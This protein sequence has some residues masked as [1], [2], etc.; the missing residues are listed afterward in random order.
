MLMLLL[1]DFEVFTPVLSKFSESHEEGII[2]KL[3]MGEKKMHRDNVM[4][5]K[6]HNGWG[7]ETSEGSGQAFTVLVQEPE[8]TRSPV[9]IQECNTCHLGSPSQNLFK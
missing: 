4:G 8:C 1:K 9:T 3:W 7:A 5:A 2:S 6:S